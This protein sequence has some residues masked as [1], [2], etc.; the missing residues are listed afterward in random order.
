[1]GIPVCSNHYHEA[2]NGAI[3]GAMP[4]GQSLTYA[5]ASIWL[6]RSCELQVPEL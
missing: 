5:C 6:Q 4:R 1:M 3:N 2:I